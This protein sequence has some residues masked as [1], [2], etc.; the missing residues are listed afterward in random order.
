MGSGEAVSPTAP[1]AGG[2][3]LF[4]HRSW[5]PVPLALI[6]V[7]VRWGAV[8]HPAIF[9]IGPL[10][11]VSGEALRWWG[12]SQIGVISR[13]RTTRLGP[14]ITSGPFA[15]CRNPLYVGNLLLWAGFAVWSGLLWML[16]VTVGVFA[17]YYAS[18]IGWEEALLTDRFGEDYIRYCRETPRWWPRLDRVGHALASSGAHGWREVVFSERGTLIAIVVGGALLAL[19]H[20]FLL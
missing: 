3:W 7:F 6:L 17:T 14:L 13:T 20:R 12:V 9:V 1:V 15:L 5:L 4:R 10:L 11:V 19:R 18:I 8:L 16:P 2:G